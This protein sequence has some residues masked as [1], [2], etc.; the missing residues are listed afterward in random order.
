MRPT[1]EVA[2]HPAVRAWG[3]LHGAARAADSI[4]VLKTG[5]KGRMGRTNV[6]RLHGIRSDRQAVIAKSASSET[7]DFERSIYQDVLP[8]LPLPSLRCYGFLREGAKAWLFVEDAE[9]GS[10]DPAVDGRGTEM[11]RWLG[12]MHGAAS[13]MSAGPRLPD[14]GPSHYLQHLRA[15]RLLL[16]DNLDHPALRDENRKSAEQVLQDLETLEAQWSSFEQMCQDAPSTL[17]HGDLVPKNYRLRLEQGRVEVFPFDWETAGWG[18]PAAD[19]APFI[20]DPEGPA[21]RAYVS[22]VRVFWPRM[23]TTTVRRLAAVGFAFRLLASIHWAARGIRYAWIERSCRRL[24]CYEPDLR[25][26]VERGSD[27]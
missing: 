3:T 4:E 17:V 16:A 14:R 22:A 10:L 18:V 11:A 26:V 19:L 8:S 2:D 6:Y 24:R 25:S 9:H 1:T 23:D 7:L 21:L 20:Q 12:T 13:G 5:R 27:V 15:S